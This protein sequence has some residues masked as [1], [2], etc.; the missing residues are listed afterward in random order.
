[1]NRRQWLPRAL[2]G[3]ALA[4]CALVGCGGAAVGESTGPV[5]SGPTRGA[6]G[7]I[8]FSFSPDSRQV[9]K[10]GV[11]DGAMGPDGSKDVVCL[12]EVEGPATALF[13]AAVTSKG[14]PTGDFQADTLVGGEPLPIELSLAGAA[15]KD[16]AGLFVFEGNTLLTAPDGSLRP[17]AAGR[18]R[19][20]LYMTDHAA[21]RDGIRL[22]VLHPGGSV[23]K[24]A[25]LH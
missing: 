2:I 18:H 12:A 23:E 24:S 17:L 20:T 16:S 21:I 22:F 19:L 1:M 7:G 3:C 14:E 8:A 5:V 25:V 4:A 15:G 9:D 11:S 10:V 13:V 6:S